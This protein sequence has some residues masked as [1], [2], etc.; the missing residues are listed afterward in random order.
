MSGHP[1]DTEKRSVVRAQQS[2]AYK[3][4]R[5]ALPFPDTAGGGVSLG[6]FLALSV[7]SGI[8]IGLAKVVTQLFSI[9]IGATPSQVALISAM[10]SAGMMLL[11]IPAGFIVAQHGAKAIYGIASLG[12]LLLNLVLP[13]LS[14]WWLVAGVRLLIGMC[15]PFRTVSMN[16]AFL[17]QLPHIG[18]HRVGWYRGSLMLGMAVLGPAFATFAVG[19]FR[20]SLCFIIVAALFGLMALFSRSFFPDHPPKHE[21]SGKP[22]SFLADV[23]SMLANLTILESCIT[24]FLAGTAGG[25]FTSFVLL[26]AMD[27]PGLQAED[28]VHALFANGIATVAALFLGAKWLSQLSRNVVQVAGFLLVAAGLAAIGLAWNLFGLIIGGVLISLGG[29]QLPLATPRSLPH[30]V[31][32]HSGSPPV[33]PPLLTGALSPPSF[34]AERRRI[35][36]SR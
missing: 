12:P 9:E 7:V 23:R 15:I 36:L 26:A 25:L 32:R 29:A 27:L 11:T 10:E 22:Q 3:D 35:F 5:G 17:E 34:A 16:T 14:A 33:M 1:P 24:E 13:L 4:D 28:G 20:Y 21:P 18:R 2:V 19:Y 30:S 8:T 6:G 31:Q